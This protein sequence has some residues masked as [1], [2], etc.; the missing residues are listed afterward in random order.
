MHHAIGALQA[1]EILVHAH[2]LFLTITGVTIVEEAPNYDSP[3]KSV[4][5]FAADSLTLLGG[6]G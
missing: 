4:Q 3:A 5:A 1:I 2:G 6:Q